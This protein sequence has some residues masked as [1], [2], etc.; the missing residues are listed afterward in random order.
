MLPYLFSIFTRVLA[1]VACYYLSCLCLLAFKRMLSTACFVVHLL[2]YVP[3]RN[4]TYLFL[5]EGSLKYI[6]FAEGKAL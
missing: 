5:R 2:A 6:F 1:D 4:K 3:L